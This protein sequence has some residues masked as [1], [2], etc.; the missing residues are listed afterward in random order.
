MLTITVPATELWNETQE[1]FINIKGQTLLL[2]HSLISLSKWEEKWK[3]PFYGPKEKTREQT[4]DYLRC[5]TVSTN[6]DPLV[7]GCL[8]ADNLQ[9]IAAYIEDK[10]TATTFREEKKKGPSR[11]IITAELVYYWMIALQIPFECQK[12]HLNRLLTLVQVCNVKNA[13]PKKMSKRELMRRNAALNEE[14]K[15]R[16]NTTG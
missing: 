11:E 13:P 3:I 2:E 16:L 1:E 8:T 5:M 9:T 10:H 14:R 4:M 7:Y 15:A 12:W 6:V